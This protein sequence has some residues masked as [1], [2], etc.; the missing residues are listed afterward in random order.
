MLR[1]PL[2]SASNAHVLALWAAVALL[3]LLDALLVPVAGPVGVAANVFLFL[4]ALAVLAHEFTRLA[5]TELVLELEHLEI[6]TRLITEMF[7]NV[8]GEC[9]NEM[10]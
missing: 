6:E 3:S 8:M 9:E 4:C 1:A 7:A 2:R 5:Y 10:R